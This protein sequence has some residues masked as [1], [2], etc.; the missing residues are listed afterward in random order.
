MNNVDMRGYRIR[1]YEGMRRSPSLLNRKLG[2]KPCL[3]RPRVTFILTVM[4]SRPKQ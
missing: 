2:V 4:T 1:S 3:T